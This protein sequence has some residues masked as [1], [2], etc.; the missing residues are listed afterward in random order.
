MGTFN[1]LADMT[2]LKSLEKD[3]INKSPTD[4]SWCTTRDAVHDLAKIAGIDKPPCPA[5]YNDTYDDSLGQNN[6]SLRNNPVNL[7]ART[8]GLSG[9]KL[10]NVL[11]VND[12]NMSKVR[13]QSAK[14]MLNDQ[15]NMN[16]NLLKAGRTSDIF[17]RLYA[18]GASL[19]PSK[20]AEWQANTGKVVDDQLVQ[21]LTSMNDN[22]QDRVEK[23]RLFLKRQGK[24]LD[25]VREASSIQNEI[26]RQ[27]IMELDDVERR[28]S[29]RNRL[30]EINNKSAQQKSQTIKAIKSYSFILFL[31]VLAIVAHLSGVLSIAK[32][33]T[34]LLI[35]VIA[36]IVLTVVMRSGPGEALNK[37][38]GGFT[39]F[40]NKLVQEGDAL[41]REAIEW[42][43]KNC[44]CSD[45]HPEIPILPPAPGS[46]READMA[47]M[48]SLKDDD[49]HSI[50][51]QDTIYADDGS[52]P[53][54]KIAP[55]E[56][57][58]KTGVS[59]KDITE[60]YCVE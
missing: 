10:G 15:N 43:N 54:L 53:R 30:V 16:K 13:F 57:V 25:E 31:G 19:Y 56:F 11:A 7:S 58:Q 34:I 47:L 21:R 46:S 6:L 38:E 39:K 12:N 35:V 2:K 22:L 36:G 59:P 20:V 24:I 42:A 44:D 48:Q 45:D 55:F 27:H 40:Q 26:A 52:G 8:S 29:V 17:K 23:D 60:G 5:G 51:Y 49:D 50:Y 32:M 33:W 9:A 18:T 37:I 28:I 41:N 4:S 3:L 14:R 1:K